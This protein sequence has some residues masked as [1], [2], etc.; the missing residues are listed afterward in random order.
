MNRKLIPGIVGLMAA[1]LTVSAAGA[2][3]G[4]KLAV[5]AW[6][7]N[8]C[9][10]LETVEKTKV[11]G[12]KYI[13][14]FPGQE[15]GGGIAGKMTPDMDAATQKQ[16]LAALKKAGVTLINFG[17]TGAKDEEGW[18]KL[19]AW[20]KAMGIQTIVS[21][22]EQSL[23]PMIDKL[24][25]KYGINVAIHNHPKPSRYWDP[26]VQISAFKGLSKRIGACADTGH[27]VRSE[28]CP[29]AGLKKL[30]GRIISLHFKDLNAKE[31]KAHDVPWGTGISNAAALLAEMKRQGFK[32]V[33][34]IEYEHNTPELLESV[35]KCAV[36]FNTNAGLSAKE[37]AEG[38][39]VAPGFTAQPEAIWSEVKPG[40]GG[41]WTLPLP[42]TTAKK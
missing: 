20:A 15:I 41:K 39:A 28:L 29:C 27:W 2:P 32:G 8:K 23:L 1:A 37:L 40:S 33:F 42:A 4:W 34:S 24:A 10:F 30:Q 25:N 26:E 12:I 3:T 21:E 9:T 35:K 18:Q 13:E 31:R 38:K 22:P 19:F 14:A 36:Y 11:C 17:V 6:T 16:V 5:Q 7:F